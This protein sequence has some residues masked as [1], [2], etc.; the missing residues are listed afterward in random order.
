MRASP[1][2][3]SSFR[4]K[5]FSRRRS[6]RPTRCASL[7]LKLDDRTSDDEDDAGDGGAKQVDD[8]AARA[9]FGH[10]LW[11]ASVLMADRHVAPW[12]FPLF[13]LIA[14]LPGAA[15][16]ALRLDSL[17]AET[18]LVACVASLT[19]YPFDLLACRWLVY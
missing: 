4:P 16:W 14:Y 13:A 9:R 8:S 12:Q 1:R 7:T 18:C 15:V 19:F 11:N 10:C 2:P 5:T 17:V 3:S 6:T